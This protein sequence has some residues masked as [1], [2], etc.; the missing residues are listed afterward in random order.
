MQGAILHDAANS[1]ALSRRNLQLMSSSYVSIRM[2]PIF[3]KTLRGV[4]G[5]KEMNRSIPEEIRNVTRAP[6]AQICIYC[7]KKDDLTDEHIVPF[8]LGGNLILPDASC[9]SCNNITR[10]FEQKVLRGFMHNARIAGKFPTRRPK[11]RPAT[12]PIQIKV[13][14]R[15]ESV[16]LPSADAFGMLVLPKLERA[17]FLDGKPATQGVKVVGT[18]MIGFG[19]S[20]EE[21]AKSL[22]T[23]TLQSTAN[24]D[25]TAFVRM[26]AKIGYSFAVASVGPFP[27]AEVPVLPLITGQSDDGSTW[28]GSAEYHIDVE[29]KGAQFALQL[30]EVSGTT[31]GTPENVLVARVKLFASSG[32]TGYEVVVRRKQ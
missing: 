13:G 21:L 4:I 24:V 2:H 1:P 22:N 5:F 18:Q 16:Q 15:F 14:D 3:L 27:L 28:V 19:K 7:G 32:A 6:A 11:E 29:D 23:K 8:A 9:T 17:A 26:L 30:I 31:N 20:P 12:I 25:V 10:D